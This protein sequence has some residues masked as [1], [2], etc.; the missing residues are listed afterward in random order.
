MGREMILSDLKWRVFGKGRPQDIRIL[1]PDAPEW[2]LTEQ[3]ASAS[4]ATE[5]VKREKLS[6]MFSKFWQKGLP[7]TAKSVKS[8]NVYSAKNLFAKTVVSVIN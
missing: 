8:R 1:T 5:R 2:L 4:S 6:V 3:P 7:A